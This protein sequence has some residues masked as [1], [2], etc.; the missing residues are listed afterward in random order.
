LVNLWTVVQRC[1]S[2]VIDRQAHDKADAAAAPDLAGS[3]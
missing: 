3:V 1:E 2:R